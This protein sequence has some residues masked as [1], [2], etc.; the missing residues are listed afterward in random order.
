MGKVI[1][2]Q[3]C[4]ANEVIA[5][6]DVQDDQWMVDND[7]NWE[8]TSEEIEQFEYQIS[9]QGTGYMVFRGC[10]YEDVVVVVVRERN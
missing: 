8:P 6:L 3:L 2:I 9:G 7:D 4:Q 10:E 1:E 5:S